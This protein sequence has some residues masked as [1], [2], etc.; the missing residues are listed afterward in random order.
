[1]QVI[2]LQAHTFTYK[3]NLIVL[4][5]PNKMNAVL[6][7]KMNDLCLIRNGTNSFRINSDWDKWVLPAGNLTVPFVTLYLKFQTCAWEIERTE[8]D[9]FGRMVNRLDCKSICYIN[10]VQFCL[11]SLSATINAVEFVTRAFRYFPIQ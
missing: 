7:R 10:G 1:M 6:Q 3:E 4:C 8:W 5:R 9:P 11:P 2:S